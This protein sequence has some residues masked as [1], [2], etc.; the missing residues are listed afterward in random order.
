MILFSPCRSI[1]SPTVAIAASSVKSNISDLSMPVFSYSAHI[2]FHAT[3]APQIFLL[4]YGAILLLRVNHCIRTWYNPFTSVFAVSK[5][6]V[7]MIRQNH[8]HPSASG[9]CDL[10]Q[11]PQYHYHRSRW[12]QFHLP[13]PDRST[14]HE[15][16]I[17]L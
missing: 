17:R 6:N 12:Y 11:L 16:H 4:G 5:R 14:A 13:P 2:S 1:T 10:V 3:T 15:V 8:S 7:M 9:I